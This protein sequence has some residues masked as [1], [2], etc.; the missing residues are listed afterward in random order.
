MEILRILEFAEVLSSLFRLLTHKQSLLGENVVVGFVEVHPDY[1]YFAYVF[2]PSDSVMTQVGKALVLY[3]VLAYHRLIHDHI[4][5]YQ[6]LYKFYEGLL[7]LS[8]IL[9]TQIQIVLTI[10]IVKAELILFFAYL[11]LY[12]QQLCYLSWT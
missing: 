1:E 11:P 3:K 12:T 10:L 8:L 7:S 6:L 2:L 9:I 4:K 5:N